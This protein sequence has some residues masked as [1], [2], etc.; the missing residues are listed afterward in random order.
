MCLGCYKDWGYPQPE[1]AAKDIQPLIM[2]VDDEG[3]EFG[4][5]HIVVGDWN[6]ED[7]HIQWCLALPEA[8][9]ADK[10]IGAALMLMPKDQRIAAFALF[11]GYV[12]SQEAKP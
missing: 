5:L 6:V 9:K 12:A 8:T 2:A 7:E 4:A 3:G 1:Q 10:S 11:D